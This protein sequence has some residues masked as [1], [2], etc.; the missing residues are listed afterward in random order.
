MRHNLKALQ[1]FESVC[2]NKSYAKAAAELNITPSAISHQLR[3]LTS[4][5]GE[6]LLSATGGAIITTDKGEKLARSLTAAFTSI[7]DAVNACAGS[8]LPSIRLAVCSSFGTGIA[9]PNMAALLAGMP[10]LSLQLRMYVD[11]PVQTDTVA[12]AF[13]TTQPFPDG[14]FSQKILDEQ[15]VVVH[16]SE[17][18]PGALFSDGVSL[19]TTDLDH[20]SF[21]TEW[22]VVYRDRA[23]P[24]NASMLQCT[25][26]IFALEMARRGLGFAILPEF[27]VVE[28][29]LNDTLRIV[30]GINLAEERSYYFGFKLGREDDADLKTLG[31]W[32]KS[33]CR[34][35]VRENIAAGRPK[36]HS[37]AA[38]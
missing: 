18:K 30:E 16:S 34:H 17:L 13:V 21:A 8:K 32:L 15:N 35:Y 28:D 38:R 12:D 33:T 9:I 4:Y 7:D 36:Q 23:R 19:I 26:Y 37:I 25:H 27:L 6:R 2:R 11:D 10:H 20:P 29:V 24:A 5:V 3:G 1:V 14:Y 22:D 31:S